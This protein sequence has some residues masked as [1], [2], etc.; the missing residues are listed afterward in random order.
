MT[1]CK[2][3]FFF[4][5]N[6]VSTRSELGKNKNRKKT[7]LGETIL[8]FFTIRFGPI[9][10]VLVQLVTQISCKILTCVLFILKDKR[11]LR[12]TFKSQF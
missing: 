3:S 11:D 10:K 4:A 8:F 7:N 6:F 2:E 1:T 5:F 12:S 9:R